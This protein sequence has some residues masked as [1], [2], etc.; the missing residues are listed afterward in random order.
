MHTLI[1][2]YVN[3]ATFHR[4]TVLLPN[5]IYGPYFT[6]LPAWAIANNISSVAGILP[7]EPAEQALS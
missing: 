7:S 6:S 2:T 5:S 1:C 4:T 3:L